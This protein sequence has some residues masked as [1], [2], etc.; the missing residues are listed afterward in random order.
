LDGFLLTAE[1]CTVQAKWL[2]ADNF[3]T[4][5][6]M[7]TIKTMICMVVLVSAG[8]VAVLAQE[9]SDAD[10]KS[11]I[12]ALESAWNQAVGT[13]DTKA[14]NEIF[15]N[16][17]VYVEHDG[18]VMSKAEYLATVKRAGGNPQQVTTEEMMA[19]V[20]GT[21]AIVTGIFRERGV[22]EG[23][24]YS[25]RGRFIDTWIFKD[26]IWVCVAAQATLM[27]P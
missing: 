8:R 11:K 26:R 20:W 19:H 6:Y 23:K 22:H 4:D 15:D 5:S 10:A 16:F 2:N 24:P 13:R 14:L 12:L 3:I 18:R 21:T 7:R 9:T 27:K 25:R 1:A 17:L